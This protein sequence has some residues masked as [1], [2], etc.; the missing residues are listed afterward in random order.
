[1][2]FLVLVID[3]PGNTIAQLNAK[4]V[5][6]ASSKPHEGVQACKNILEALLAGAAEGSVQATTRD[7]DPSV[8]TSGSGSTQVTYNL[9]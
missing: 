1:M 2:A 3:A 4:E 7:T 6:Q 5:A 8:A 9:K